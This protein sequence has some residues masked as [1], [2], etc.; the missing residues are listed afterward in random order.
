MMC[1]CIDHIVVYIA[2]P[3]AF[4]LLL[5]V[6]VVTTILVICRVQWRRHREGKANISGCVASNFSPK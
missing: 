2:V 6:I 4:L 1:V 3:V 5:I